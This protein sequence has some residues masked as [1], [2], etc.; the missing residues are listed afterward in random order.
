MAGMWRF[1]GNVSLTFGLLVLLVVLPLVGWS[2]GL[3]GL[4]FALLVG[5]AFALVGAGM[6]WVSEW[7]E[8]RALGL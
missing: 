1:W 5:V 7:M 4:A 8:R 2:S 6:I 3:F